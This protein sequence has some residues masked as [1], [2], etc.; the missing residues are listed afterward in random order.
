MWSWK[1][2]YN[3]SAMMQGTHC[4]MRYRWSASK[5]VK[6]AGSHCARTSSPVSNCTF[7]PVKQVN[8]GSAGSHCARTSS[9]VTH[10]T[11]VPVKHVNCGKNVSGQERGQPLRAQLLSRQ[12]LYFCTSKQS[13]MS[14]KLELCLAFAES[15]IEAFAGIFALFFFLAATSAVVC[16]Q[17]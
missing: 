9:P 15:V 11:F 2:Q 8:C 14:S 13:K 3:A 1:I 12:Y 7:V 6:G 17:R 4:A 5:V 10:C 16:L